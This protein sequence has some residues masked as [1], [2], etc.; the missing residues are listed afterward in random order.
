MKS[1]LIVDDEAIE[2]E[3]IRE[4]LSDDGYKLLTA[5]NGLE[6]QQILSVSGSDIDLVL[7]DWV[8][9]EMSGLELLDWIRKD[10]DLR[11]LGVIL[12]SGRTS[13]EDVDE[14]IGRG[15][16]YYLTKPYQ[17]AQL[18]AIVRA[19][20]ADSELKQDLEEKIRQK[21]A[22][23]RLMTEGTF[24][25]RTLDEAES[26]AIG[27]SSACQAHDCGLG[28]LEL[29]INAVEHGN[30]QISYPEKSRLLEEADYEA[31]IKRR[32][33]MPENLTKKVVV[34][35]EKSDQEMKI[36]I[37]DCGPGFDFEKYLLFDQDRVFDAHGRGILLARAMVKLEYIEPGNEVRVTLPLPDN[38]APP[39]E[40]E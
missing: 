7:L 31:E 38:S 21:R 19:A 23:C 9:P 1:I 20:L 40:S 6:A 35:V 14:G 4:S 37:V 3:I 10:S 26:L 13:A 33:E 8:M 29:L 36:T 27:L 16:Y 15:A 11:D 30:L 18:R 32:L 34:S 22:I 28:L 12:Q 5:R 39:P 17:I 25:L 24:H 2:R